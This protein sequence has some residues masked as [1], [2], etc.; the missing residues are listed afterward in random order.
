MLKN[1]IKSTPLPFQHMCHW[2]CKPSSLVISF[3]LLTFYMLFVVWAYTRLSYRF[4]QP[5]SQ[6]I[7]QTTNPNDESTIINVTDE[8]STTS[9]VTSAIPKQGKTGVKQYACDPS[10]I[11]NVY[12]DPKG[13]S[14]CPV[15]FTDLACLSQC[16]DVSKRCK[17]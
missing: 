16:Q 1:D 6:T 13:Q 15:T 11:C 14:Q 7:M 3:V 17:E 9:G 10:G 12:A 2:F 8:T 5:S 4:S